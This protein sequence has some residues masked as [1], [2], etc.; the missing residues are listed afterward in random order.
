MK[1]VLNL[2]RDFQ[3][4]GLVHITG[5][6]LEGNIP[7]ILPSSVAACLEIGSWPRPAIFD[8]IAREGG[9]SEDEMLR[10]FNCGIGM[11]LVVPSAE[12]E[13]ADVTDRLKGLGERAYRVGVIERRA[14][15]E[16]PL[17][18]VGGPA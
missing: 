16:P 14:E 11:L 3:V 7:R 9:I 17:R 1:A 4:K 12:A 13:A 5:G 2:A 18:L 8:W 15:G 10:V 6:G